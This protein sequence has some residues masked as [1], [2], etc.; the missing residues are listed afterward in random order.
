MVSRIFLLLVLLFTTITVAQEIPPTYEQDPFRQLDELLPTPSDYRAASGAPGHRYWQQRADYDINVR[1]VEDRNALIGEE[2]IT[3]HNN[4]PMPLE[5]LWVQLDQNRFE[6]D[7]R[8][9]TTR[10]TPPLKQFTYKYLGELLIREDFQGGHKITKVTD[11][12]DKPLD[13][14]VIETMLRIDLPKS[15]PSGG[16]VT[17]NIGWTYQIID[18]K[19]VRVRSGHEYFEEDGNS[20]YELAQWFPRMCAYT[21]VN[22]W[23]NKQFIRRGEFSLEFGDYR[24]AITTPDDHIVSS[25]GVLQN[26]DAVLTEQQRERLKQAETAEVPQFIVTPEEAKANEKE[27][28]KGEKTWVF[29]AENVR[30]FAWASSRKFIWDAVQ[31]TSHGKDVWCMSYYPNEGEPLWSKYSTHSIMHTLDVYSRY[32]FPYPYPVAISVNGPV[33]G[34]EYP[35]ICFNGPRPDKDGTYSKRIKYGLISVIIHEVGHNYFPMI[36][37]SDE[38]QWTWIDE[39]INSFL[40]YLAEKEWETDYPSRRGPA[41]NMV[42]YMVSTDQVPIMTNSESIL[43][44]GHNAYGKPATALNILRETIMGR[45]LFDYA[46]KKFSQ[47]WMF[48]RPEPADLFRTMEDASSIDLDW[49]WRGWFYTTNHVDIAID[50]V[51]LLDL[52]SLDPD[53]EKAEDKAK[54]DQEPTEITETRNSDVKKRTERY[55]DLI[56]FYNHYDPLDVTVNDREEA[57]KLIKNLKDDEKALLKTQRQFYAIDFKN[58]GGVIMPIILKVNYENG[59]EETLRLPAEIWRSNSKRISKLIL[60]KDR[61]T[62]LQIDP[63]EETADANLDNNHWP[64]RPVKSRFKLFNY[65]DKNPM[66]EAKEAA[67]VKEKP[68]KKEE[69]KPK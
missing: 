64:S 31:H 63:L 34:M 3:Y 57:A 24:V 45:E 27:K 36:V 40:Q 16:Q 11:A 32:T 68:D 20:I 50:R 52:D 15:L 26:P 22:G 54:R 8:D 53:I 25:T 23:Q 12:D 39:G 69:A 42:E 28:G 4:S 29:Q 18:A 62:S 17:F 43:Q 56:D 51:H 38:R 55:P 35:M 9:T 65:K 37:N 10:T 48:K 19:R 58:E 7:S 41:K 49:F 60:A 33:G 61:I 13:H 5:Y 46:F 6:P 14:A 30:D 44:F 59:T 2:T 47:R 1:L 66:R 21:D 67:E